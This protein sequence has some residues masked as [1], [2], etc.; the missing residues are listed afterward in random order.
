MLPAEVL[1]KCSSWTEFQSHIGPLTDKEKGDVF[2]LLVVF[3]L[4][5]QPLYKT[6]LEKVWHHT[7]VPTDV[8]EHLNLPLKDK[9]IDIVVRTFDGDYWTV[10]AKYRS[11]P[12]SS[13]TYTELSTFAALSF[14]VPY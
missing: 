1:R 8:M 3:A 7:E 11:D 2:E 4:K 10:Q 6:K 13:L 14:A 5:L 9:G 12:S